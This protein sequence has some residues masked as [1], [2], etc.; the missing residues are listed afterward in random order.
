MTHNQRAIL[1]IALI[2][3]GLFVAACGLLGVYWLLVSL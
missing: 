1:I 3:L 2:C